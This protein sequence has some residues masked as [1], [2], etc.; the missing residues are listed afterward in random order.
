[1]K[2]YGTFEEV[3][4]SINAIAIT[5]SLSNRVYAAHM[6]INGSTL[7]L[8]LTVFVLFSCILASTLYTHGNITI[9]MPELSVF[10]IATAV[11][12]IF[13]ILT[14]LRIYN[15]TKLLNQLKKS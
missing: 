3:N 5:Q 14:V 9:Q 10:S 12:G 11:I 13:L 8:L 1:M 4:E 2:L 6:M 15:S 7:Y